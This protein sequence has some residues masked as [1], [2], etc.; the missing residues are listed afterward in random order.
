MIL[1]VWNFHFVLNNLKLTEKLQWQCG[2]RALWASKLP[3]HCQLYLL[4]S[5]K[6]GVVSSMKT[7]L[8]IDS[9]KNQE[10]CTK[11]LLVHSSSI[12]LLFLNFNLLF[13]REHMCF[14][15][16]VD[17]DMNVG[18]S[19]FCV[20]AWVRPRACH[21]MCGS[22]RTT[23]RFDFL[24]SQWVLGLELKSPSD[25]DGKQFAHRASHRHIQLF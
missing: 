21:R 23:F 18:M 4:Y 1:A 22:Q 8:Y 7:C 25:L 15:V 13:V 9:F 2:D 12:W 5:L 17:V 19:V 3:G 16:F 10:S 14:W 24:L 20:C 11:T 6:L